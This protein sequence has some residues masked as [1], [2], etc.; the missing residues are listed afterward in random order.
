MN[1]LKNRV[2]VAVSGGGRSLRNLIVKQRDYAFEICGVVAS[3]SDCGGAGIAKEHGLPLFVG[4]FAPASAHATA[5]AMYCWLMEE[6]RADW[7]ALA[8]FLKLLPVDPAWEGRILNIHPALLPKHGGQGMY[9]M[10]VHRAV[11]AAG[12]TY[13]GATIHLVSN[14]YDAGKIIAQSKVPLATTDTPD[15]IAAKVFAAECRL[16]PETLHALVK[17]TIRVDTD[18]IKF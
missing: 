15:D 10:R 1:I 4:D 3:R 7:L 12:D 16:Y 17:G 6:C 2:A 9:G 13:S 5:T 18:R 11:K 14:E 8:G